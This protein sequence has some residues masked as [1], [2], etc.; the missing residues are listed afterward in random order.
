M[1]RLCQRKSLIYLNYTQ[2]TIT[3]KYNKPLPLPLPTKKINIER[4]VLSVDTQVCI[5]NKSVKKIEKNFNTV[6]RCTN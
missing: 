1:K 2:K 5:W 3:F 6:V 4:C